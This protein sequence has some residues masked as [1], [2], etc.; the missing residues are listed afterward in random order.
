MLESNL[1]SKGFSLRFTPSPKLHDRKV[2]FLQALV[3]KFHLYNFRST[4]T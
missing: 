1:F 2:I 4:A 3:F